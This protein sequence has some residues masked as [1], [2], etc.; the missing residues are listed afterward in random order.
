MK[1]AKIRHQFHCLFLLLLLLRGH[2]IIEKR[3]VGSV[4]R[5]ILQI[6]NSFSF[7]S[8]LKEVSKISLLLYSFIHSEKKNKKS[9]EMK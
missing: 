2:A 9:V 5:K 4:E 6:L 8:T 7:I 1:L 3:K